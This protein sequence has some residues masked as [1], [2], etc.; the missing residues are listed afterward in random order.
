MG[1]VVVELPEDG[2]ARDYDLHM[3]SGSYGKKATMITS[4]R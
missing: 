4:S 1:R 3:Q 2:G